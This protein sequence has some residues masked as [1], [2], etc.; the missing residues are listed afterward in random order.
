M[1]RIFPFLALVL[2]GG[3]TAAAC[4]SSGGS[5][6]SQKT[7][8]LATACADTGTFLTFGELC[9]G[10]DAVANVGPSLL[11]TSGKLTSAQL[12]CVEAA[13]DCA[14]MQA[15]LTVPASAAQVCKGGA[16]SRCSGQYAVQCADPKLGGSTQ[17]ED[18]GAAGLVCAENM[19]GAACGTASCDP[20]TTPPKCD[21]DNLVTCSEPGGAL[22]SQSCKLITG[23]SC[24]GSGSGS[25]T[26]R[27]QVAET[28]GVVNGMA[29]CVGTGAACDEATFKNACDGTSIVSCTGGKQARFDCTTESPDATCQLQSDGSAECV[30]TGTQCTE[31]TPETCKDGVITYCMWGTKTT[32]D[33]T[34]YGLSGC[35]TFTTSVGTAMTKGAACTP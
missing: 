29:Q 33:C 6:V 30:G 5:G 22:S 32:V 31:T 35:K 4:S 28:C 25:F 12:D 14:T 19:A 15:C 7:C 11:G 10:L 26:C 27:T 1:H 13:S 20:S 21:G 17:G 3:A 9:Q 24:S 18:C 2:A 8:A 23:S 34:A 16:T